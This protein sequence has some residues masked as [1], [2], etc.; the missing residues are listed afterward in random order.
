MYTGS[1]KKFYE[2]VAKIVPGKTEFNREEIQKVVDE[3]GIPF[4]SWLTLNKKYRVG[5]G[6]YRLPVQT[7]ETPNE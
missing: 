7:E 2:A 1:R 4:P 3:A 5:R 6:I